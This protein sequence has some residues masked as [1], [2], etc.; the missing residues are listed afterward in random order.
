[1]LSLA[2]SIRFCLYTGVR[3]GSLFI[4]A[5]IMLGLVCEAFRTVSLQ[6]GR[7][8]VDLILESDMVEFEAN[9]T[10]LRLSLGDSFDVFGFRLVIAY[11]SGSFK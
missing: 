9:F 4:F 1:M 11:F 5:R 2:N 10:M 3:F 6:T 7:L 8:K